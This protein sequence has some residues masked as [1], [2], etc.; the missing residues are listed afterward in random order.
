VR[1]RRAIL[2]LVV[3]CLVGLTLAARLWLESGP[4]RVTTL[5]LT[6]QIDPATKAPRTTLEDFPPGTKVMYA[7]VKV[8]NPRRGTRVESKWYFDRYG[9]GRYGLVDSSFVTFPD[10]RDRYVAFSLAA[11]E[12]FPPGTYKV[13]ILVDGQVALEREFRVR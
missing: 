11:Q 4:P 1:N 6:T 12:T 3:L 7:V 5:A 10:R 2:A 13:S 9:T 8:K